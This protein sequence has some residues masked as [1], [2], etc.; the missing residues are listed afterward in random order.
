MALSV[1][2]RS[3]EAVD[4]VEGAIDVIAPLDRELGLLLEAELASHAQQASPSIRARSAARL[5]RHEQ[6]KGATPG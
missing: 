4:A 5:W 1:D 2:G 6:L 3:D